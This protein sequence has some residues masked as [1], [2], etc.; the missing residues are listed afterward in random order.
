MN[1]ISLLP[2][3]LL[4][5]S[6]LAPA[7]TCQEAREDAVVYYNPR[8][9]YYWGFIAGMWGGLK[10]SVPVI[11]SRDPSFDPGFGYMAAGE[12]ACISGIPLLVALLKNPSP[13]YDIL[14]G[15]PAE[16]RTEYS[17]CYT[18]RANTAQNKAAF[19]GG[20]FGALTGAFFFG[21]AIYLMMISTE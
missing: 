9:F 11:I 13:S 2:L 1:R 20:L 18:A 15:I 4:A 10:M 6:S 3:A 19:T 14:A 5:A 7:D 12:G 16:Q 21:G 8:P 17:R